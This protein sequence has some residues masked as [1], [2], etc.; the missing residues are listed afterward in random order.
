MLLK[1]AEHGCSCDVAIVASMLEAGPAFTRPALRGTEADAA[2][3][4][5]THSDGDHLTLFHTFHGY[6]AH[7]QDKQYSNSNN[8]NS[9]NTNKSTSRSNAGN[10]NTA[11]K[12]C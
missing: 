1:S 11:N 6:Y 3:A 4:T 8:G 5:F 12:Y 2:H 10:E 7:H 9:G